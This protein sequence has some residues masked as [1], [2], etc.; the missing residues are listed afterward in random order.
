MLGPL[1]RWLTGCAY[2][3]LPLPHRP[4]PNSQRVGCSTSFRSTTSERGVISRLQ[5]FV[6]LQASEFA[7]TQVVPTAEHPT[8]D[9]QGGRGV[10][11]RA[12]R[13]LLPP[14]ASDMLAVRNRAI[15]GKGLSPSRFAALPA[16]TGNFPPSLSPIPDVNLSI[17]PARVTA[18]RLPP[19]IE[20]RAPPVAG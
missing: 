8:S 4:S 13:G 9:A 3:F 6:D 17:H 11:V 2:P 15:D 18:Q 7:A 19:S 16:A 10:Y 12:Q 1:P 20:C 5:S 14:R